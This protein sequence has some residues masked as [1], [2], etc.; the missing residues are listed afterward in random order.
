MPTFTLCQDILFIFRIT[1][2]VIFA[3]TIIFHSSLN[4]LLPSAVPCYA[5]LFYAMLYCA[6]LCNAVLC[7]AMLCY[8]MLCY[9]ML[10]YAMLCYAMLCYAMLCYAI[11]YYAMLCYAKLCYAVMCS[12]VV[13]YLCCTTLH[14]LF[15][16]HTASIYYIRCP[17]HC[18]AVQYFVYLYSTLHAHTTSCALQSAG[19]AN[20][21]Q[22]IPYHSH[23]STSLLSSAHTAT[24]AE[25]R[26]NLKRKMT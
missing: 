14:V 24:P 5:V 2:C 7:Y 18:G 25:G 4:Y 21:M 1:L 6:M 9:A 11:L 22:T 10:C 12:T 15:A 8:A 26:S 19:Q 16:G 23:E 13:W 20:N 17:V 3:L